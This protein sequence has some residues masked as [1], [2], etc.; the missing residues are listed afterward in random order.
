VL[1]PRY[2]SM[3]RAAQQRTDIGDKGMILYFPDINPED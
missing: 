2:A 1:L 3:L